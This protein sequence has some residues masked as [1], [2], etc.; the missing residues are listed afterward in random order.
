[1]S[2]APPPVL[3]S[4]VMQVGPLTAD[5]EHAL[6]ER[7]AAVL[8]PDAA[9]AAD[10]LL[11]EA[12]RA[13]RVAVTSGRTGVDRALLERLPSL[14]AV[15][16][17]GV[18]YERTDVGAAIERGVVVG[19]TPDVL[20]G[21]VADT[22]VGLL[23]DVVRGLSRADRFVRAGRWDHPQSFPLT[24]RVGG[25]RVGILGLGRIGRAVARRLEGFGVEVGHHSRTAK[26]APYRSFDRLVDLAGWCDV[27]VVTAGG[28]PGS[29]GLVDA[30]VLDAL[31]P[32]GFLV[33][34]GRGS[35]VDEAALV[36]ALLDGRLGGAGLDVF[37]EEPHVPQEL[38]ALDTVVLTPHLASGT[39][40]TRGEMVAMVLDDVRRALAGEPLVHPVPECAEGLSRARS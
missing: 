15:V 13:V 31:G 6:Q 12:G 40:E 20:T 36:A 5:L 34:V 39:V 27:L 29:D 21:C 8:L 22:A 30:A 9:R 18:G 35:V 17:F 24:T 1:M 26:A 37:A 25:A 3:P 33:N 10:R 23:L 32:D 7:Y 38:L 28:G 19:H 4:P 16:S 2:P 11:E 14:E